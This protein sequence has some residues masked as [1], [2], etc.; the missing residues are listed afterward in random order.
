MVGFGIE[1]SLEDRY[2]RVD[3]I[4][5]DIWYDVVDDE[6]SM[7]KCWSLKNSVDNYDL[8]VDYNWLV[9][10]EFFVEYSWSDRF[11]EVVNC[12]GIKVS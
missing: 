6:L 7:I 5:V 8:S 9:M 10:I 1:F 4:Y 2:G 11:K 12:E 3:D